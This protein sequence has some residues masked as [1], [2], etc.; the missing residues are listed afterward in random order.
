MSGDAEY[1]LRDA[2]IIHKITVVQPL[3]NQIKEMGEE[4]IKKIMSK[5]KNL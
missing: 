3:E 1:I 5:S 2:D 4:I